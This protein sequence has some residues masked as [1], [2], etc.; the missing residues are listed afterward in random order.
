MK[1]LF[2]VAL[3]AML[4]FSAVS[5]Q[6]DE[7][8][9]VPFTNEMF[10]IQGVVPE[11]WTM[12]QPGLYAR[13]T[14]GGTDVTLIALQAAP[15]AVD[16]VVQ[17]LLPRLGL[18]EVPEPVMTLDT[19]AFSW[20]VYQTE[21]DL[22]VTEQDGK[23]YLALLQTSPE[24][25]D[26]LHE[27]VFLPVLEAYA[28][29]TIEATEEALPY[30]AEEVTFQNGDVTLAG[31]LT[32]PEGEGPHPAVVLITGSGPQDRD[33][34]IAPL[35]D[36]KP[37]RLIADYLT[38]NGI[39]VLRYDDRGVGKSTG[40]FSAATTEDFA[41]D[42]SAGV[43]YLTTRN[44]INA[45]Q[46]GILGHSEGGVAAPMV[47]VNNENVAF[48]IG[49]AAPAVSGADVLL[50]QNRRILQVANT[51]EAVIENRMELFQAWFT[52]LL[53][54]DPE[55]PDDVEAV[56]AAMIA[57]VTD[58]VSGMN[59]AERDAFGEVD[60]YVEQQL[61]A[62]LGDWWRFFLSYNPGEDWAQVEV[63]VLALYGALD[64]QVDAEQNATAIETALAD[65]EDVTIV[66]LPT[67]NHLFQ[68]AE[69][70]GVEEYGT[71]EQTFVEAFLP[72]ITEWLLER[73][74]IAGS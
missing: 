26:A 24:E 25:F 51:D 62:L 69:T 66:T 74:D 14:A 73:V 19:E 54:A 28:P 47:A 5:A 68:D 42:A 41:N 48:V 44:D 32:L 6:D 20:T 53:N 23:T 3:I 36:I 55:N 43:D 40:N 29:L 22:A 16:Q 30:I 9:L 12:V 58:Q 49:M 63:P 65:N 7:I 1:L 11:G 70:G 39:A 33:E 72:T 8:P 57:L 4:A 35:A 21:V 37:F 45:E 64:V 60:A 52:A 2:Q 31:T 18:T 67:A 56:R 17:S 50:E 27:S 13:G 34:S 10:G 61:P 59:K 15:A 71:L 38:R 46:I